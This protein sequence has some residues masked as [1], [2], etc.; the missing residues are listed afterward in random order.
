LNGGMLMIM[1]KTSIILD[2]KNSHYALIG[3]VISI[4]KD[5]YNNKFRVSDITSLEEFT[6]KEKKYQRKI[7]SPHIKG[8]YIWEYSFYFDENENVWKYDESDY[9]DYRKTIREI[10]LLLNTSTPLIGEIVNTNDYGFIDNIYR[11]WFNLLDYETQQLYQINFDEREFIVFISHNIRSRMGDSC[12]YNF[13]FLKTF[14]EAKSDYH[15][16]KILDAIFGIE[17]IRSL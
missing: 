3:K 2:D 16:K 4:V 8:L 17:N 12:I 11:D 7:F 15:A 1:D 9:Y 13:E 5:K 14:M 6:T 10:F